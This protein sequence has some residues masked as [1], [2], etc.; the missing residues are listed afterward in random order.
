MASLNWSLLPWQ[1]Q[2]WQD[3]HR[4]KVLACGRRTGKSN[5]AI[6][7]TL[8]KALEA[9]EGAA[10]VYVAPTLGQARQIAW[11]ALL[12]GCPCEPVRHYTGDRT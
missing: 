7:M 12:E 6:K 3:K 11:D 1:L 10:V 9:P 4:F 5:L 2:V 8:A